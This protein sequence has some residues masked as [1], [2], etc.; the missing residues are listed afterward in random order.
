MPRKKTPAAAREAAASAP[1]TAAAATSK[2]D[3]LT[4]L[5]TRPEGA[6]A[7]Q[8]VEATGWQAHS[9]RGAMAGALK[10]KRK[11]M[12]TSEKVDGVRVY[13]ATAATTEAGEEGGS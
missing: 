2:L 11:L 7:L 13:R 10:I 12:I 5:L 3:I 8:M 4:S 6:T 9:V 1:P